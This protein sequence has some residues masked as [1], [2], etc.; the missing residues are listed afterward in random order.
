MKKIPT[1]LKG[2]EK[3]V[4]VNRKAP[5][6]SLHKPLMERALQDGDNREKKE[7]KQGRSRNQ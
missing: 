1:S 3:D 2:E 4:F 6:A 7:R 5:K